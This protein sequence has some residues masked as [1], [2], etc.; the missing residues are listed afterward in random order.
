[1]DIPTTLARL[2]HLRFDVSDVDEQACLVAA[3]ILFCEA[4]RAEAESRPVTAAWLR[5]RA[6][7]WQH[8]SEATSGPETGVTLPSGGNRRRAMELPGESE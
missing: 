6:E 3:Q 5:S 7:Q 4:E 2:R 8:G 1:M